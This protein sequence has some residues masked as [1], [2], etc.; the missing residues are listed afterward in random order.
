MFWFRRPLPIDN[1]LLRQN[2]LHS[3]VIDSAIRICSIVCG[4]LTCVLLTWSKN[5]VISSY[6]RT[7]QQLHTERFVCCTLAVRYSTVDHPQ[8]LHI[9]FIALQVV[10]IGYGL[11]F[12]LHIL[13]HNYSFGIITSHY[14]PAAIYFSE[15]GS[16][17]LLLYT[18]N[19]VVS[20]AYMYV[21]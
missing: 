5:G 19:I 3:V 9:A 8:P 10:Y 21:W 16:M 13:Y 15:R 17:R 20:C 12:L 6:I 14:K 7:F 1:G 18:K 4:G 11:T 2:V